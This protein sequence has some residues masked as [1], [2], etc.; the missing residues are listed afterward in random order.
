M[1]LLPLGRRPYSSSLTVLRCAAPIP[2]LQPLLPPHPQHTKLRHL[3]YRAPSAWMETACRPSSS[4]CPRFA[5]AGDG[6][7]ELLRHILVELG[8]HGGGPRH[9][10]RQ[11]LPRGVL[12]FPSTTLAPAMA[13]PCSSSRNPKLPSR[14]PDLLLLPELRLPSLVAHCSTE[15]QGRGRKGGRAGDGWWLGKSVP[16]VTAT[17]ASR[18]HAPAT[19][20][21]RIVRAQPCRSTPSILVLEDVFDCDTVF[22]TQI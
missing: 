2:S 18:A 7:D 17:T 6:E 12:A 5:R 3:C 13:A 22:K 11:K 10:R 15:V 19:I 8:S 16:M 21:S 20:V 1:L 14:G 9:C 4:L